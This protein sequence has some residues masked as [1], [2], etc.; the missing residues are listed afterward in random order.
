[1]R[2]SF[3]L[4]VFLVFVLSIS[5]IF[6]DGWDDLNDVDKAWDGQKTI[7][8]KEYE[9]VINALE[10]KKEVVQEKK[11]KKWFKNF[12]GG[13]NSL[14]NEMNYKNDLS[15]IPDL[16]KSEEGVLLNTPVD[17]IVDGLVLEKGYYKVFG[18]RDEKNTVK[19]LFYQSQFLKAE[20]LVTETN[21]D[22]G[23]ER[24]DFAKILYHDENF[25]KLIFGSVDFN[26]FVF[27]P[28]HK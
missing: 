16:D 22:Y 5:Q 3:I 28:F 15:E 19:L 24:I 6:A 21:D 8:N 2:K 13:G 9:D 1:M 11:R 23:E 7:T 26:A 20:V 12:I 4:S 27:L 18:E 10:E 25:V 17:L 14:H